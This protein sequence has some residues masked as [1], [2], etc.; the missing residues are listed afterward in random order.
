[1]RTDAHRAR[2]FRILMHMHRRIVVR[3]ARCVGAI[4]RQ[5]FLKGALFF[6]MSLLYFQ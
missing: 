3:R 6:L 2:I 4:V 5:H 1:M